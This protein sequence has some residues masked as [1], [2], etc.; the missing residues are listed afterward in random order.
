MGAYVN[1]GYSSNNN[2]FCMA[3]IHSQAEDSPIGGVVTTKA[4][5]NVDNDNSRVSGEFSS[6]CLTTGNIAN[7]Y[8]NNSFDATFPTYSFTATNCTAAT[9]ICWIP[10]CNQSE[11]RTPKNAH[12]YLY[13][14]N[15]R[16]SIQK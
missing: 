5:G 6:L 7:N 2:V 10:C 8:T 13:I 1:S 11:W 9:R 15:I 4:F 12:Y 14:D 3:G 16:V